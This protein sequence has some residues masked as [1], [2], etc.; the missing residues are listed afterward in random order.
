MVTPW[1]Q[2][3]MVFHFPTDSMLVVHDGLQAF[4]NRRS[5]VVAR[6]VLP[7]KA[8]HS[9]QSRMQPFDLNHRPSSV[10]HACSFGLLESFLDLLFVD[11]PSEGRM[12][13]GG[14]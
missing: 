3:L 4:S 11:S 13:N 12:I 14:H 6:C 10:V 9:F 1:I 8:E 7:P 5:S 2:D